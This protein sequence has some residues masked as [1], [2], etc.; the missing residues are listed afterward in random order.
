M[1]KGGKYQT[2]ININKLKNPG[3][4]PKQLLISPKII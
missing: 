2:F 3:I 1:K 4:D